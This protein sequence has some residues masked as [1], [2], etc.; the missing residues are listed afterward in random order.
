MLRLRASVD[1]DR[2]GGFAALLRG[3]AGVH[4]VVKQ[5][6]ESAPGERF[7]FVADV[8]PAAADR[9]VAELEALGLGGDDYVLTR[10]DVVAPLHRHIVRIGDGTVEGAAW[11]EVMGQA[12]ANS[13]PLGRYVT[14]IAVAAVIAA[15]GVVTSNAILVVG[16]MAVSPDLLPIC[17]TCVGIVAR[18]RSL[19]GRALLTL[20]LGLAI[21]VLVAAGLSA[22]LR[23]TDILHPGFKVE[24][25]VVAAFSDTD[26]ST[27]LVAL[28]A[29]VAAIVC[30]E[31]RASAAVGVGI[32]VTTIPASAFL[33][34][35][36]GTEGAEH[37]DGALL[38]LAINVGLLVAS[39]SLTLLIQRLLATRLRRRAAP[40]AGT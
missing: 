38:V 14:L 1:A 37:A 18:R 13:R 3:Q 8:E 5:R 29:G 12:R 6:D 17:A 25:S 36:L 33:G 26:Y 22:A 23:A 40:A 39:G 9:L 16:A 7:V 24:D 2:A 10:T 27:V 32:S 4:R 11:F 19:A 30:F 34:V 28:A 35:A 21:V 31:T 20:I 15:L